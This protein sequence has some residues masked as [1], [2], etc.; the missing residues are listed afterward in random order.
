MLK[1]NRGGINRAVAVLLALIGVM[2]VLIS[3]PIL[4]KY[5]YQSGVIGC[6]QAMASARDGL[7]LEYLKSWDAGTVQQA[8]VTLDEVMPGRDE[9]CPDHGIVYLVKQ[10]NGI[11]EPVC[12]L[13]DPD[14]KQR[15]RLNASHALDL[16]RENLLAARRASKQE[17][18]SVTIQLNGRPLECVRVDREEKNLRRGTNAT[19]GYSGIVAYYGIA[20]EGDFTTDNAKQGEICYFVYADENHCGIW[21]AG[22]N[23]SGDAYQ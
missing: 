13:H 10:D 5:R 21:R 16:L 14:V 2:L 22:A 19:S 7:I 20:G 6:E 18:A 1:H 9:L 11:F 3:I 15:V 23:W 17:P 12:G 4:K 8:M